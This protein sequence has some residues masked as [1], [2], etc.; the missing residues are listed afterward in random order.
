MTN[1]KMDVGLQGFRG[2]DW[3]NAGE[4]LFALRGKELVVSVDRG[5]TF[6]PWPAWS[7]SNC[8]DDTH[9]Y[10]GFPITM[11]IPT[12]LGAEA[13]RMLI[14][15]LGSQKLFECPDIN[16]LSPVFNVAALPGIDPTKQTA[17]VFNGFA[18]DDQGT[19]YV[20][21]YSICVPDS[22]DEQP[23]AILFRK[24]L[25]E[26]AWSVAI[27][28]G[29]RHVHAVKFNP[30]NGFLYVV[31]GEQTYPNTE[32]S[33]DAAKVLR[34]TDGGNTWTCVTNTWPQTQPS[35]YG[36]YFVTIEFLGNRVVV[37]EDTDL[38]QGRI[39][40]FDDD[41]RQGASVA[42]FT[43]VAAFPAKYASEFFLGAARLG[44]RLYLASQFMYNENGPVPPATTRCVSST[45]GA[46]WTLEFEAPTGGDNSIMGRNLG[47][48]TYHPER[49]NKLI[50]SL[51]RLTADPT[52]GTPLTGLSVDRRSALLFYN[53]GSSTAPGS[54]I[55][56]RTNDWGT[57]VIDASGNVSP[58][59]NGAF[60]PPSPWTHI[61][62]TS[63]GY[64]LFY[65]ADTDTMYRARLDESGVLTQ[66]FPSS[67]SAVGGGPWSHVT[68]GTDGR[69]YFYKSSTGALLTTCFEDDG[70]FVR[71]PGPTSA[72][73]AGWSHVVAI[74]DG[75]LFLYNSARGA[76]ELGIVDVALRFR[77]LQRLALDAGWTLAAAVNKRCVYVSDR[78]AASSV[79]VFAP[80]NSVRVMPVQYEG[81]W[82]NAVGT[83]FG[84]LSLYNRTTGALRCR[85]VSNSGRFVIKSRLD[86]TAATGWTVIAG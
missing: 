9:K 63:N 38:M 13:E 37:G 17:G 14:S 10:Y 7:P 54:G 80:Q 45:D 1:S 48:L 40:Y 79:I 68:A 23:M 56:S 46:N 76:A 11:M 75:T 86:I 49:G 51:T 66:P 3:D 84:A 42:P 16:A 83:R 82:T 36:L 20:G 39:F 21:W 18:E 59:T 71:R 85:H 30:Y 25:K 32:R 58:G 43:P 69:V 50:Y 52:T 44:S 73:G 77:T 6:Q 72:A 28:W 55:S 47:I 41:G 74:G 8:P 29:A 34:S 24:R 57:T 35:G 81:D 27:Q 53:G 62:L 26:T 19:V 78:V 67:L 5:V 12:L 60:G 61:V 2:S 31:L 70:T 22:N 65:C 64:V 15:P 33:P 4:R